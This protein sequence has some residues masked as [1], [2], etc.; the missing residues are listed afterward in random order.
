MTGSA[1]EE[2][3]ADVSQ[4]KSATYL[5][6]VFL[7]ETRWRVPIHDRSAV[8]RS[9][10]PGSLTNGSRDEKTDHDN[11]CQC[12][13]ND[14]NNLTLAKS[15]IHTHHSCSQAVRLV[16]CTIAARSKSRAT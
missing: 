5:N 3:M 8:G 9:L 11:Q 13:N 7:F 10:C 14:S 15:L 2:R 4:T 12:S 16:L 6:V 1:L